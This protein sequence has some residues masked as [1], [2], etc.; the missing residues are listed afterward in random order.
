MNFFLHLLIAI[1]F[2]SCESTTSQVIEDIDAVQF[3]QRIIKQDGIII[4]VRT[5]EE[6]YAGHIKEATNI[7]FYDDEFLAKLKIVRKD[8]PIYVYC[9]SGGRSSVAAR[10]MEE[11]G[12]SKVYNLHGGISAWRYANYKTTDSKEYKISTQPSFSSVDIQN[13]LKNNEFV[14]MNFSTQWCVP[15]R[16]MNPVI[17]QLEKENPNVKVLFI[18]ADANNELVK[19]YKIKAVPGFIIFSN[20]QEIFRHVGVIEKE[21]LLRQ[22]NKF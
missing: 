8:I 19:K 11:L 16:K 21:E 22:M 15:C 17:K 14:L 10:K 1:I 20:A 6:F 9:K 12:F 4:D 13:F 2:L 18:D 7:D 3:Q 5:P